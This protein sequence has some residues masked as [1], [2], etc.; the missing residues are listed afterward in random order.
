[1]LM[2]NFNRAFRFGSV[3][4]DTWA[5][6]LRRCPR[7]VL[8]LQRSKSVRCR[9]QFAF[10]SMCGSLTV[11]IHFARHV[12]RACAQDPQ[13]VTNAEAEFAARGVHPNRLYFAAWHEDYSEFQRTCELEVVS[14]CR[15]SV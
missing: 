13:Q 9:L 5:N 8:V 15:L 6:I 10:R 11:I 3:A 2:G 4:F 14:C 7:A 12:S 1:M